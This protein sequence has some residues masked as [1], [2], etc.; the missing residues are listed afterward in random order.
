MYAVLSI[1]TRFPDNFFMPLDKAVIDY[2]KENITVIK[3]GQSLI[4]SIVPENED[5]F[6]YDEVIDELPPDDELSAIFQDD[7]DGAEYHEYSEMVKAVKEKLK[8]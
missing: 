1:S 3:G 2:I 7:T 8:K 5:D 6:D 4:W